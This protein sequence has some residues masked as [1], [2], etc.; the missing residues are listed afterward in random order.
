[1]GVFT[2]KKLYN[3]ENLSVTE[4]REFPLRQQYPSI[5]SVNKNKDLSNKRVET[6]LYLQSLISTNIKTS[7]QINSKMKGEFQKLRL[8]SPSGKDLGEFNA[9]VLPLKNIK[10]KSVLK[11]NVYKNLRKSI[12]LSSLMSKD[13]ARKFVTVVP[14]LS[15]KVKQN[16]IKLSNLTNVISSEKDDSYVD[17]KI[18]KHKTVILKKITTND[19]F[20]KEKQKDAN[21]IVTD[22]C[23]NNECNKKG[24]S[25]YNQIQSSLVKNEKNFKKKESKYCTVKLLENMDQVEKKNLLSELSK[26]TQFL[27]SKNVIDSTSSL[28]TIANKLVSIS[29]DANKIIDQ[30]PDLDNHKSG[31]GEIINNKRKTLFLLPIN[32]EN[33]SDEFS[34]QKL[35]RSQK[36]GDD[37]T[38]S[39][40]FVDILQDERNNKTISECKKTLDQNME[41]DNIVSLDDNCKKNLNYDDSLIFINHKGNNSVITKASDNENFISQ[42]IN[43]E[44]DESENTLDNN[45][46]CLN[47]LSSSWS[48]IKETTNYI[49]DETN[50]E[51]AMKA[52]ETLHNY[53]IRTQS[54][55]LTI[56]KKFK[57][58]NGT[59]LEE[60]LLLEH[61][62]LPLTDENI[63]DENVSDISKIKLKEP[64][65]A[66]NNE[67]CNQRNNIY[68]DLPYSLV[69]KSQESNEYLEQFTKDICNKNSGANKVQQILSQKTTFHNKIFEQLKK[70]FATVT[71]MDENGMLNI[72]K[73]VVNN[74]ICDVKRYLMVLKACSIDIDIP[75]DFEMTS[76]ELAIK[77]NVSPEIVKLLLE[78]GA[79]PV[80]SKQIHESALIIASKESYILLPEIIK[81][82]TSVELLNNVD[83]MGFAPLHYCAQNGNLKG[84]TSL[85]NMGADIN[86]RENRCGRTALFLA[87]ENNHPLIAKELIQNGAVINIPNFSGQTIMMP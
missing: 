1:M 74:R 75:T 64:N 12:L 29:N 52:I 41:A 13:N 26:S 72:H 43:D 11:R 27:K 8:K 78:Y 84:I 2:I 49:K 83:C 35:S 14:V 37:F 17:S 24:E 31:N 9:Q 40:T 87:V 19:Q 20:H 32:N 68:N 3:M 4:V 38:V 71:K 10:G 69:N 65:V 61:K 25:E 30:G 58:L 39:S 85:I 16:D 18:R 86:L 7:S 67:N 44:S 33:N 53:I 63:S 47:E 57:P 21:T 15:M 62:K 6:N 56:S 81:H 59:K 82:V 45:I 48:I 77:H 42:N 55:P 5:T 22:N 80:S 36:E 23:I 60:D 50:K 46:P 70:D 76:L 54:I 51:K 66:N 79:N 28:T 34:K 73:A